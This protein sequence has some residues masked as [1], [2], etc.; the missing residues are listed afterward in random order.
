MFGF[1]FPENF[2]YPYVASSIQD[3][4]RRW[5]MSLSRW[6][7]DYLY[8]P[9]GGNRASTA[10]TY[11]NLIT[12]FFLCGLWHGA[13]WTFVIW[14]LYHGAFLVLERLAPGLTRQRRVDPGP[15]G[16]PR[17]RA[18]DRHRWMGVLS[19]RQPVAR[20]EFPGGDGRPGRT[21]RRLAF[22]PSWYLDPQTLIAIVLGIAGSTPYPPDSHEPPTAAS[23]AIVRP[24]FVVIL[25]S[26]C[27]MFI[28]ARSYNPF[29]YFRF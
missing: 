13:N 3:F 6:F 8:V 1:R 18:P 24:A 16:A 11:A 28:A 17:V 12:V 5:H 9:L 29:I 26:I 2:N 19:G 27:S 23:I 20:G 25:L 21:V 7:R 4:W 14:G 10:R 15:R 22:A